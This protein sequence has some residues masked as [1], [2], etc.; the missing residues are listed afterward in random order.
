MAH[1]TRV[2]VPAQFEQVSVPTLFLCAEEDS[3]FPY[4][5][6]VDQTKAVYEKSGVAHEF[7]VYLGTKHG[8]AIRGDENNAVHA[9]AKTDAAAAAIKFFQSRL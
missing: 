6:A 5:T 7:H 1:P 4:P 8:F 2:E 3:Q 9:K